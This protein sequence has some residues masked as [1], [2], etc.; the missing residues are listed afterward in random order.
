MEFSNTLTLKWT[1]IVQIIHDI[2]A[3][4]NIP[5]FSKMQQQTKLFIKTIRKLRNYIKKE[6]DKIENMIPE[7]LLEMKECCY[8][9]VYAVEH[10]CTDKFCHYSPTENAKNDICIDFI[11]TIK[12]L[13]NRLEFLYSLSN[14]QSKSMIIE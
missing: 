6:S 7:R 12:P 8:G 14:V 2:K 1:Q 5:N 3:S 10:I 9:M 11:E 4:C 13:I